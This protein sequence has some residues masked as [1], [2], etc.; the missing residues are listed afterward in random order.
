MYRGLWEYRMLVVSRK[1]KE[2][3][4][5]HHKGETLYVSLQK[6]KANRT[7]L[8]FK[9]PDSFKILRSELEQTEESTDE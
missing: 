7:N 9:G 4:V 3:V 2:M 1:E 6:I 5:V 8:G